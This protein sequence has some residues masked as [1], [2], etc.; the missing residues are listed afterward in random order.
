MKPHELRAVQLLAVATRNRFDIWMI[1]GSSNAKLR[2]LIM[3]ELR[4]SKVT[5][6]QA[7]V[8]AMRDAFYSL[9]N[10]TGDCLAVKDDAFTEWALQAVTHGN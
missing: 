3:S 6:A 1:A 2:A 10:V 5:Q 4:G 9:A 7:G 8:N